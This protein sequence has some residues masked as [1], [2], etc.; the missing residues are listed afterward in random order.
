[1]DER[2]QEKPVEEPREFSA[3]FNDALNKVKDLLAKRQIG[4][5]ERALS[6]A[7]Q[8][9]TWVSDSER[10]RRLEVFLSSEF[11]L[12]DLEPL[13]RAESTLRPWQSTDSRSL[14]EVTIGYLHASGRAALLSTVLTVFSRWVKAGEEADKKLR[15]EQDKQARLERIR[16]AQAVNPGRAH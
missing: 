7:E 14:E 6:P 4:A 11:W 13:L 3:F 2:T 16:R 8:L 9:R 1:M 15:E 5:L 10:A 12:K